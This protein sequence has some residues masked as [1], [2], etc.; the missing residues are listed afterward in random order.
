M[1]LT[2]GLRHSI[3][4]EIIGHKDPF[5]MKDPFK[6]KVDGLK[7]TRRFGVHFDNSGT[8]ILHA[9]GLPIFQITLYK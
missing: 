7:N 5:T 4:V 1:T 6:M 2:G 9:F 3:L 8:I